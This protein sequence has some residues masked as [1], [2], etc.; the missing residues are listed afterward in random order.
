MKKII[1]IGLVLMFL[2]LIFSNL[3]LT[4][5]TIQTN[6]EWEYL[7]KH[8]DV[9]Q[10]VRRHYTGESNVPW[11]DGFSGQQFISQVLTIRDGFRLP[12]SFFNHWHAALTHGLINYWNF[13]EE[14]G[15][16]FG[17]V[18][19]HTTDY[20][21]EDLFIKFEE[22]LTL[23]RF[24]G[25]YV[26]STAAA[27]IMKFDTIS[28][29]APEK[30][31]KEKPELEGKNLSATLICKNCSTRE[32]QVDLNYSLVISGNGIMRFHDSQEPFL[33]EDKNESCTLKITRNGTIMFAKDNSTGIWYIVHEC[34]SDLWYARSIMSDMT[35]YESSFGGSNEMYDL[36]FSVLP[37][38]VI[39]AIPVLNVRNYGAIGD[40]TTLD[41]IAINTAIDT[42]ANQNG[43]I[44][45]FPPGT[46]LSGSLHLKT[47]VT[48]FVDNE[49]I[50]RGTRDMTKYDPR[51]YNPWA[52][53]QDSSQSYCHRSLIWGENLSNVGILGSG[54]I[55]GNDAFESWPIINRTFPPPLSWIFSTIFYQINDTIFQRGAKPLA[56]KS[57]VNVFIKDITITHA[58]DESIFIAGCD[59]VII[60]GYRA[61]EVRVDGIDPV[62]CHNVT[63]SNCEI[64]SLDDAIAIKSSYMLGFKRSC[65]N[66]TVKNCLLSTYINALKI[67]TE[68]VGNLHHITYRNCIVSNSPNLP[69]YAG[70]SIISVDGGVVDSVAASDITLINVN[71]PIFIRL[72]DRLRSPENQSV[73]KI[74]N[75]SIHNLTSIGGK[76][77]SSITAVPGSYVGGNITFHNVTIICRG[78][79]RRILSYRTPLE[80]RESHGVYPDPP[81][82][83][84][85]P[86]PAYGFF[87]RHVTGLSFFDVQLGFQRRD[88]RA[89]L[90]CEDINDLFLSGFEAERAPFGSPS[91]II[92][93]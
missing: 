18:Y 41:T 71:Y 52:K 4:G 38:R 24:G 49:A 47:N 63:I 42:C 39:S 12:E 43:G 54:I 67:G 59:N 33:G 86:S 92:R 80:R 1:I 29:F 2:T 66:I 60:M 45:Y 40:G 57:C 87:C 78:G 81:Y 79:G 31:E 93:K 65:E 61:Q 11:S 30:N 75:I 35:V 91:I 44:V 9:E 88:L 15:S 25:S 51:E 48:L 74:Q 23:W 5:Q 58:P 13:T 83:L 3:V 46:Y 37:E 10:E 62:C 27:S 53:Y 89:A 8:G 69:S 72:G 90:I 19:Y 76:K 56:L 82:I 70:I 32:G 16:D 7:L 68:S 14:I 36:I 20:S 6:N 26:E 85:G 77:A 21:V 28:L 34:Y 84:P 17:W 64:R 50:L 73:G 55:D 22:P